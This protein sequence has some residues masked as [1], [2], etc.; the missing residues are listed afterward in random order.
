[1]CVCV[2][3]V[4]SPQCICLL[5]LPSHRT[6]GTW[7]VT[8]MRRGESLFDVDINADVSQFRGF[9]VGVGVAREIYMGCG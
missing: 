4:S 3:V 7:L 9:D 2:C 5:P 8:N 1:M 6:G